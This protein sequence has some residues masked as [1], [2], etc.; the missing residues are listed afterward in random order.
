MTFSETSETRPNEYALTRFPKYVS[1]HRNG[2]WGKCAGT[3]IVGL[4][5]L[6]REEG[7]EELVASR[8]KAAGMSELRDEPIGVF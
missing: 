4:L 1:G 5:K 2:V 7:A 6:F 8:V 3:G